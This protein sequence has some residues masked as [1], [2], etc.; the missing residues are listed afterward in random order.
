M[1]AGVFFTQANKIG[2]SSSAANATAN[3]STSGN[4]QNNSK[5]GTV[6]QQPQTGNVPRFYIYDTGKSKYNKY[7]SLHY[8]RSGMKKLPQ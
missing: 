2:T 8:Y 7:S 1:F 4:Q 5:A 3:S 6:K